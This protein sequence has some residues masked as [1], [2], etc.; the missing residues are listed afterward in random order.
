MHEAFLAA[1]QDII[2]QVEARL[3]ATEPKNKELEGMV[4]E[5]QQTL[6]GVMLHADAAT[7]AAAAGPTASSSHDWDSSRWAGWNG[8]GTSDEGTGG[9][10][11]R[12]IL[13]LPV[14]SAGQL[15]IACAPY[16][17]WIWASF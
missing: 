7:A 6:N 14:S 12:Q 1:R 15:E 4:Q 9:G 5:L 10:S 16:G 11:N 13:I 17:G 2:T 8:S 3:A